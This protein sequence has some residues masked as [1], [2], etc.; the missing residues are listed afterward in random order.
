[1]QSESL[2]S[3]TNLNEV[4]N[5]CVFICDSLRYDHLPTWVQ[6]HGV[7]MESI[8]PSSSTAASIPSLMT[9]R[10][11][12]SHGCWTFHDDLP[13]R[14]RLFEYPHTYQ[15]NTIWTHLD[16]LQKPP[17]KN[18][19]ADTGTPLTDLDDGFLYIEHDKGGHSPYGYSFAEHST[20]SFYQELESL[21]DIPE[22]YKQSIASSVTRFEEC[23]DVL[24]DREMLDETLVVFT[25]DHGEMLG[26]EEYGGIYGHGIPIVSETVRTPLVFIGAGLPRGVGSDI[27]ASGVYLAPTIVGALS[28]EELPHVDGVNLWKT[29]PSDRTLRSEYW[30]TKTIRG[31]EYDYYKA[32]SG[33]S[34]NGGVVYHK[35][36][37]WSRV[38]AALLSQLYKLP[39]ASHHRRNLTASKVRNLIATHAPTTRVYGTPEKINVDFLR[40][41]EFATRSGVNKRE[42]SEEQLRQLGYIE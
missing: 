29:T 8:A 14:P 25:S 24:R 10:Y 39:S 37:R 21:D 28:S 18:T 41:V 22:L 34:T 9:G 4:T 19:N 3:Y 12:S 15:A 32:V 20:P 42:Y 40:K 33:W 36:P 2:N 38:T 30:A 26:E 5:V 23:L 1:M 17:I 7:T 31:R 16:A 35:S 27:L 13:D 11:P 6:N